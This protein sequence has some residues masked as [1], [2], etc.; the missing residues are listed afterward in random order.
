MYSLDLMGLRKFIDSKKRHIDAQDELNVELQDERDIL[1]KYVEELRSNEETKYIVP[2]ELALAVYEPEKNELTKMLNQNFKEILKKI[3]EK[4]HLYS[5]FVYVKRYILTKLSINSLSYEFDKEMAL[6]SKS[7]HELIKDMIKTINLDIFEVKTI[8]DSLPLSQKENE[9]LE[10]LMVRFQSIID[11]HL[12]TKEDLW[13]MIK[14]YKLDKDLKTKDDNVS[15]IKGII[16]DNPLDEE[17]SKNEK[18]NL[19][20][21]ESV[22]LYLKRKEELSSLDEETLLSLLGENKTLSRDYLIESILK[23]EGLTKDGID[24]VLEIMSFESYSHKFDSY[25]LNELTTL[26]TEY[27]KNQNR[28]REEKSK[29][30]KV[31]VTLKT[32][33]DSL[34]SKNI[35]KESSLKKENNPKELYNKL[36]KLIKFTLY[37]PI[38]LLYSKKSYETLKEDLNTI[39]TKT[40]NPMIDNIVNDIRFMLDFMEKHSFTFKDKSIFT[41]ISSYDFKKFKEIRTNLSKFTSSNFEGR[42]IFLF[43]IPTNTKNNLEI[44]EMDVSKEDALLLGLTSDMED[45][46][47]KEEELSRSYNENNL[48][49]S[50]LENYL[51][52]KRK[53]NKGLF[54][55]LEH[56]ISQNVLRNNEQEKQ[57][58]LIKNQRELTSLFLIYAIM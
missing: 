52:P 25:T 32:K 39:S 51:L 57:K 14:T 33:I 53:G 7:K 29:L 10:A 40:N 27:K 48:N 43:N 49:I 6:E 56:L 23:K 42:K 46:N 24:K 54:E 35:P 36:K 20:L 34:I 21:L 22:Y 19:K 8:N 1:Y 16:D 31:K 55:D 45:I 26:L 18:E 5:Y 47:S 58:V 12:I 11:R 41:R 30:N 37:N 50:F 13:T 38:K 3:K 2:S 4:A 9:A 17:K 28:I 44:L 15:I